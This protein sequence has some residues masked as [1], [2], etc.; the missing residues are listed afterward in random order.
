MAEMGISL[1]GN[2]LPLPAVTNNPPENTLFDEEW[3]HRSPY[4]IQSPDEF[5]P[6]QW[7]ARCQCGRVS[8]ALNRPQPLNA[9][10][11][12]CRGC[13]VMHGAPLQWA[14]I[15]HKSDLS[16][17]RGFSGLQFYSASQNSQNYHT[18]TKVS[19]EFCRTPIMD[20]GRNVCLIFPQLIEFSGSQDEQRKQ[21]EVF[22]PTCHIFYEQ[23]MLDIPDGK[24]KWSGMDQ[25]SDL[26][27]DSGRVI[28]QKS[29]DVTPPL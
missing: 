28:Q 7:R 10:F 20:E 12:H 21:R 16:F 4:H 25:D 18:P 9:K 14:A 17:A 13:Q 23:R 27:D 19:C 26:L 24:P 1:A 29:T 3:K 15:F 22:M 2:P 11:C 8:Y 5:G 6:I